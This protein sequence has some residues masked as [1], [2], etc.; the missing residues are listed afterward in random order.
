MRLHFYAQGQSTISNAAAEKTRTDF[1]QRHFRKLLSRSKKKTDLLPEGQAR[2]IVNLSKRIL[3]PS[4]EEI[5][6]K[7]LK[8]AP[9]PDRSLF[10]S[11]IGSTKRQECSSNPLESFVQLYCESPQGP[12]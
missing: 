3:S 8:F 4:Q 11:S 12:S 2:W 5:L 10:L 9:V 1:T 7:G 6:K